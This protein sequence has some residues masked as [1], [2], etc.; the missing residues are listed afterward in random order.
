MRTVSTMLVV[1]AMVACSPPSFERFFASG[2]RYLAEKRYAEAAIEFENAARVNPQSA[3]AQLKLGDVYAELNQLTFAAAA[4]E[5]ACALNEQDAATCLRSA[6]QL[7]S[8]GEHD[9]AS[10]QARIAISSNPSNLDAQLILAMALSGARRFGEA[11]ELLQTAK[12]NAPQD[13]RALK[14]LGDVQRQRGRPR[15]AETS[16]LSAIGID[17]SPG[18]RVSLAQLYVEM[19]RGDAGAQQLRAALAADPNDVL[20]NRAYASYLVST[21][22]CE[23]AEPYWKKA[24]ELSKDPADALALADYYVWLGRSDAALPVLNDLMADRDAGG[25]AKARAASIAYDRGERA[26]A[27]RMVDEILAQD[28]SSVAGLL[29]KARMALDAHDTAGAREYAHKASA[30]APEAPAVRDFLAAL[31]EPEP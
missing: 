16:L 18:T 22:Y 12:K 24:A 27:A 31:S 10:A 17:P 1:L 13:A 30:V 19:G 2:E 4:Y 21:E 26:E 7:L 23:S 11:E 25:E 14:A 6:S 15:D 29:L 20:A 5:R 8:F 3:A 9:R 28:Q